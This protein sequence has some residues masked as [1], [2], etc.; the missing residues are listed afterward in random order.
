MAI[1]TPSLG[2]RRT[3]TII[4]AAMP[5]LRALSQITL[6]YCVMEAARA[7]FYPDLPRHSPELPLWQF[8]SALVGWLL[9]NAAGWQRK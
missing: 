3:T 7:T 9:V 6:I 4:Q 5:F 2:G 1:R 8:P